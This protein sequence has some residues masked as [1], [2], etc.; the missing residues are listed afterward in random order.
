MPHRGG[1]GGGER[2]AAPAPSYVAIFFG[3]LGEYRIAS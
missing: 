3:V 1:G 2:A